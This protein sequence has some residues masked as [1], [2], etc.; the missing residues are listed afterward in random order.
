MR[1]VATVSC[2]NCGARK[3]I[4]QAEFNRGSRNPA[5]KWFCDSR[6]AAAYKSSM[7]KLKSVCPVCHKT[8]YKGLKEEKI[9]CSRTCA[10][11]QRFS[12]PEI[13]KRS[14]DIH[15]KIYLEAHPDAELKIFTTRYC[16]HCGKLLNTQNKRFCSVAC[17]KQHHWD[18]VFDEIKHTG[19]FPDTT[20]GETDRD[21][22]KKFIG[23]NE[24]YK[25]AI[26][27][28]VGCKLVVDHIDGDAC[29]SRV[30][31]V[32]LLCIDC[33]RNTPTYKNRPHKANRP[34][35]RKTKVA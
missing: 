32:R 6:C 13:R 14:S 23:E 9:Y 15:K 17:Y 24:G 11:I 34:W 3:D 35:R 2:A 7:H 18:N 19:L 25:C 33:D 4:P 16:E 12:D 26:C 30:E 1:K 29:N 8:F 5:K 21:V 22:A 31:N 27:G 20:H 28:K 10:N